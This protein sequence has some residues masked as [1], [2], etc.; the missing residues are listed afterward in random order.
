MYSLKLCSRSHSSV[1]VPVSR[2]VLITELSGKHGGGG[3]GADGGKGGDW[4]EARAGPFSTG[5]VTGGVFLRCRWVDEPSEWIESGLLE[6]EGV[7][8]GAI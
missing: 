8:T 3:K 6:H 2:A 4:F 7:P 5:K 1:R